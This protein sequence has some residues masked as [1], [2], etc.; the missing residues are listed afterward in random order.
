V[1]QTQEVERL[2]FPVA[3]RLSMPSSPFQVGPQRIQHRPHPG[4][5]HLAR[6][7]RSTLAGPDPLHL[8]L[9]FNIEHSTALGCTTVAEHLLSDVLEQPPKQ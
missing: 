6:L 1:R 3:P 2:G 7:A 5:P 4:R 9:M 8:T